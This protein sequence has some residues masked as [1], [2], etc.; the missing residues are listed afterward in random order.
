MLIYSVRLENF[1]S[2]ENAM[3]TFELGTNA[4]VGRN[5]AGKSSLLEAIGYAMFDHVAT[6]RQSDLLREGA[7][8][9][10][11]VVTFCSSLDERRY[12]VERQFGRS[13]TTRHRIYDTEGGQAVLAESVGE[14]REWIHEH[15]GIDRDASLDDLFR[16]T[17]GV[18]QGSF[19]APFLLAAGER[20]RLFD[21]LLQVDE[22][23]R[24]YQNLRDTTRYLADQQNTL[25]QDI[26]RLEGLLAQL[27]GLTSERETLQSD[28]TNLDSVSRQLDQDLAA[29]R[30]E[31]RRLDLSERE[32]H[33]LE[34]AL[35]EA[36]L[37]LQ[38]AERNR[39]GVV[40]SVTEAE[41]A[42]NRLARA[43]PGYRAYLEA[44]GRRT[45]LEQDRLAR[46]KASRE[47]ERLRL[48]QSRVQARLEEVRR[49]LSEIELAARELESLRTQVT[50]QEELRRTLDE[51]RAEGRVLEESLRQ[52]RALDR[53]LNA[54]ASQLKSLDE[55]LAGRPKLEET[56]AA[57]DERLNAL[58][59][60]ERRLVDERSALQAEL[61]RLKEQSDV[62]IRE[63]SARCPVCEAE[64]TPEHRQELLARNATQTKGFSDRLNETIRGMRTLTGQ[65]E[66]ARRAKA[67]VDQR[68][69]ELP[70]RTQRD[71]M[72]GDLAARQLNREAL[73]RRIDEAAAAAK[74][75][76]EI[77]SR[78]SVLGDP[79]TRARVLESRIAEGAQRRAEQV[80]LSTEDGLIAQRA[81]QWLEELARYEHLDDAITL[82]AGTLASNRKDHDLYLSSR[83]VAG[84]LE[85]RRVTLQE[86]QQSVLELSAQME[87][88]AAEHQSAVEIYDGAEH[89]RLRMRVE[90]SNA[91]LVRTRTQLKS[92][93]QRL[94]IVAQQIGDLE[95]ER[96]HL[97]TKH[98]EQERL[99]SLSAALEEMRTL[100]RSAGPYV[101]R[102]LVASISA[103]A[104]SF[105][106][107]IMNDYSGRLTWSED[108]E[109]S[110]EIKGYSRGFQQLSGG[111]QMSAALA[112][113]LALLRQLSN[114]NVAFFDEPT[115]HLDPERRDGLVEKIMQVKG[116][117]QLFVI[118]HDDTF[119]R[120]AQ[121][122][123]RIE[124]TNDVSMV[125]P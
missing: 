102:Q 42:A 49:N 46:D 11:V 16:N 83:E 21:P 91:E 117:D 52:A 23:D 27:P 125:V 62:L 67:D 107:D 65:R 12:E 96:E 70:S 28:V 31:L 38:G 92:Q 57:L 14:V 115:A 48:D 121:N 106:C 25:S 53:E 93:Q 41:D 24:A 5:G 59:V 116:F 88:L 9:G 18:P 71:Q 30:A 108:Y 75:A 60:D 39:E 111:E 32:V 37:R 50:S 8:S 81:S 103:Q 73:Q 104:S 77:E 109:L 113:R 33:R 54:V 22:Y 124:K 45:A 123:I 36:K 85:L 58:D 101:T 63:H 119:E 26:A 122:Y 51:A 94:Q 110:L 68:L 15:L 6:T 84:Q 40:R 120:A 10:S 43:E 29:A 105:Y 66:E 89:D 69:R 95:R 74:T 13:G 55:S 100:L 17:I 64:L 97:N 86:A 87:S 61:A 118:S 35:S 98:A 99:S 114:I 20:K 56:L 78:L 3:V 79:A 19:T 1:K 112:L 82:I 34:Q 72:A 44:E 4:I 47:L 7:S 76:V 90:E 80:K 2:Y